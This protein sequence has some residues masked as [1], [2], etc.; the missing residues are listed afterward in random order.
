VTTQINQLG[1]AQRRLQAA[2]PDSDRAA[3]TTVEPVPRIALRSRRRAPRSAAARSAWWTTPV[4]IFAL[5]DRIAS[6][7]W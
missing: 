5:R 2:A 1:R 6:G 3:T 7:R 4:H